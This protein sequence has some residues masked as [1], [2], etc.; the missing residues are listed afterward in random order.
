M[1]NLSCPYKG[2]PEWKAL[3]AKVGTFEAYRD[4]LE[5]NGEIR[6]PEI[7]FAKIQAR[8]DF[9]RDL[10]YYQGDEALMEQEEGREEELPVEPTTEVVKPGVSELFDSNPELASV[11]TP[12][13]YLYLDFQ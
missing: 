9:K 3:V 6:S 7:V 8:E 11:G 10:E 1:A 4:Y 12:Q 2:S 5:N 13:Q